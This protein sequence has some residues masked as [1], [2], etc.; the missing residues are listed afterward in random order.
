M[1]T[2]MS[3]QHHSLFGMAVRLL[4]MTILGLAAMLAIVFAAAAA[5]VIGLIVVGAALA[6]HMAPPRAQDPK[7]LEARVT[8][9]GWVVEGAKRRR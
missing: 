9:N 4:G 1:P 5:L 3:D 7:L 8:P 6:L 2:T